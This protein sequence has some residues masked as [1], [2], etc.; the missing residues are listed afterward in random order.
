MPLPSWLTIQKPRRNL[1]SKSRR[2]SRRMLCETLEER[3]LLA[4]DLITNGSFEEGPAVGQ[5]KRLDP[6]PNPTFDDMPGWAVVNS[7]LAWLDAANP[8]NITAQDGANNLDLTGWDAQPYGGVQQSINT[9]AG[10]TYELSFYFNSWTDG[11]V[12]KATADGTAVDFAYGGGGAWELHTMEF[13]ASSSSTEI[14][15]SAP[16]QSN[17]SYIGLDNVSVV[18]VESPGNQ[19]PVV[20]LNGIDEA[21]I[22]FA[23][24]FTGNVTAITDTDATLIDVDGGP[25][26]IATA[27]NGDIYFVSRKDPVWKLDT[28]TDELT[29]ITG[30]AQGPDDD[31]S[32]YEVAGLV[33]DNSTGTIYVGDARYRK[34]VKVDPNTGIKTSIFPSEPLGPLSGMAIEADGNL[35][36]SGPNRISR[37]DPATGLTT[38]LYET[39]GS[40]MRGIALDPNGNIVVA[41][42]DK[43][44]LLTPPDDDA[45]SP[46]YTSSTLFTSSETGSFV[47][48]AVDQING[49]IF[50]THG[51]RSDN[52]V[53]R[54]DNGSPT[55]LA[56]NLGSTLTSIALNGDRDVVVGVSGNLRFKVIDV[57][58][59]E[60][61]APPE[62]YV[63]HPIHAM[64][65]ALD[66]GVEF[67]D[68]V[69]SMTVAITNLLDE[70]NEFLASDVTG[71]NIAQ[72][73]NATTG[74]LSLTGDDT[75]ANYQAVLQS[76]TYNNTAAIPDPTTRVISFVANDGLDDSNPAAFASV[77][78]N[79]PPV[80]NDQEFEINE[81][82]TAIDTV[83]ATDPDNADSI[84]YAISGG[85]DAALFNIVAESGALSFANPPNYESPQDAG[86]DN[87]YD[88]IVTVTDSFGASDSG[89]MTISLLNVAPS[90]PADVDDVANAV[91]EG[92]VGTV[93]LTVSSSDP[94]GGTVTF[95]LSD[96]AGGRFQID[97]DSGV[98]A[99]ADAALLDYENITS[100]D[101]TVVANDGSGAVNATAIQTF[102]IEVLPVNDNVPVFAA[103]PSQVFS[104]VEQSAVGTVIGSS[105]ATDD[106]APGDVITYSITVGDAAGGF[107]I[108]A[109][110]QITIANASALDLDFDDGTDQ[111][112]VL[113]VNVND[114]A[115][116]ET[117]Q[118]FVNVSAVN[119]N[120][121]VFASGA[122]ESVA[123]GTTAV[124]AIVATDSDLPA[125][126]VT[127]SISGGTDQGKLRIVS[128][129]Q[130]EFIEAPDFE[131][132]LDADGDNAYEVELTADD[133]NGRT[134]TH[135]VTVFVTNVAPTAPLDADGEQ[136]TVAEGA[137]AGA[138]VGVTAA[139]TD[140]L[141]PAVTYS[142]TN[143]AGGRFAIDAATGLVSV[144]DTNLLDGNQ[145]HVITVMASD[146]T[147][148]SA[149]DFTISVTNVAPVIES[150]SSDATDENRSTDGGVTI[151][152]SFSDV[153]VPD[154][155]SLS[156]DWGD[157]TQTTIA[158]SDTAIDQMTDTFAVSHSYSAGGIF[159]IAVTV[160]DDD[161]GSSTVA[162]S[163][164]VVV[165][166][167]VNG[168]VLQ[169][170]GSDANEKI[171]VKAKSGD[172]ATLNVRVK[173]HGSGNVTHE[174]DASGID[175]IHVLGGG[176]NDMIA[177]GHGITLP[178]LL[179]GGD[180]NDLIFGGSG[181][182]VIRG[183]N[184]NDKMF[185]R[186]GVDK[187]YGED[188]DDWI[189]GNHDGDLIDGGAGNDKLFGQLGSDQIYGGVGDDKLFGGNGDDHLDGGDGND[190][191]WGGAGNDTLEGGDGEDILLGG[192]GDDVLDGG[193]GDDLIF[194]GPGTD[195][196]SGGDGLDLI[197]DG[198]HWA[199]D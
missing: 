177:I 84:S 45:T 194:G 6:A 101:I 176:G 197:F 192:L 118:V 167:G 102:T 117:Q 34:I 166:V 87:V 55:V 119:D 83:S 169:I 130:L 139:S 82:L 2:N 149:T 39:T 180:G 120:A 86:G 64:E 56:S 172:P 175:S 79:R 30:W 106:D 133:G 114:G 49:D 80:V 183:G 161:G 170:V 128:G 66:S 53:Y 77:V 173:T 145:D 1:K 184:G 127:Y 138:A 104:I 199:W 107:A 135:A 37:L 124:G 17:T 75:A 74:V 50:A 112:A 24:I 134:T 105:V 36:V 57:D 11:S 3:R 187:M 42:G 129:N 27:G 9:T 16:T 13:T 168:G 81:N 14:V 10:E 157:G 63:S 179:Q 100:H 58:S 18:A 148:S 126:V 178:T 113:T 144:A 8:W 21:G 174:L 163:T 78:L 70:G 31:T 155:H 62:L 109:N 189:W 165:G 76:I 90:T 171:T 89:H 131:N 65:I 25:I 54:I 186:R 156:I 136:N 46:S 153:G 43:I 4:V 92:S 96:D 158:A 159:E 108:D 23:T 137:T 33:I 68:N 188:G 20:D 195:N 94:A 103:G 99:V 26:A 32:Y 44:V 19:P 115:H 151:T 29:A 95:S 181:D 185:G 123:E 51:D 40:T 91:N 38:R 122:T 140:P 59:G 110:G 196:I 69:A 182:D 111:V 88:V 98:V 152:G 60:V 190:V 116:D 52:R 142:L 198:W 72:D 15:L 47:D 146:G 164:A 67:G 125:Q 150:L 147:D 143:D 22:D 12:I 35:I 160:V 28:A 141:G 154:L 97:A 7:D 191:L 5:Y 71:T 85:A 132:P 162:H 193:D 73:Y 121:P 61:A 48:V 41:N 93:G